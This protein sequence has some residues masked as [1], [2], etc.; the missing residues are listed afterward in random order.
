MVLL[1][2]DSPA[3]MT[4]K[5]R[6]EGNHDTA[7]D[8]MLSA[9]AFLCARMERGPGFTCITLAA[10]TPG[11][12]FVEYDSSDQS[13]LGAGKPGVWKRTIASSWS[14]TGSMESLR[15]MLPHTYFGKRCNGADLRLVFLGAAP[16]LVTVRLEDSIASR[17]HWKSWDRSGTAQEPAVA[18]AAVGEFGAK[19]DGRTP[20]AAAFRDAL[21]V[22]SAAGGGMVYIA[23]G[24]YLL[25]Q[26]LALPPGT[27]LQGS[28]T[29]PGE[30]SVTGTILLLR[31]A[32]GI[33]VPFFSMGVSTSLRDLALWYP[34][35]DPAEPKPF[36][37]T[38]QQ[39]EGHHATIENLTLVNSW[40]GI[41]I[42]PGGFSLL[43]SQLV[44]MTELPRAYI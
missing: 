7:S 44:S 39:V 20:D 34:D 35:Q 8:A 31:P 17:V 22:V 26:P 9:R 42:S 43:N 10:D 19:G 28:W 16:V 2:H 13:F 38:I 25:T 18:G 36:P 33:E 23:P 27:G 37:W 4:T 1:V 24:R 12:V 6:Q 32:A 15:I 40:K 30:G 5:S 11:S 41:L 29:S 3:A 14:G 21:F